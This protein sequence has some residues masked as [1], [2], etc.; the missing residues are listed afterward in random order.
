MD[1]L[2]LSLNDADIYRRDHALFMPHQWLNDSCISYSLRRFELDVKI[3]PSI[4]FMDPGLVSFMRLQ[5]S[6]ED[7]FTSLARGVKLPERQYVFL[8]VS[9]NESFTSSSSHWSL[10][11]CHTE[12]GRLWHLDSHAPSNARAARGTREALQSLMKR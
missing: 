6:D 2:L 12:T 11:L 10:L 1:E 9:D 4:L 5:C 3:H 7:D 8:F